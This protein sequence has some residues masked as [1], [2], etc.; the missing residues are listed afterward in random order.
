MRSFANSD[1]WR[2]IGEG[3]N[4]IEA[5]KETWFE[6]EANRIAGE[7]STVTLTAVQ[8]MPRQRTNQRLLHA[9]E[10]HTRWTRT[11]DG[12]EISD[13]FFTCPVISPALASHM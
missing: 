6:A 5:T 13:L 12:R 7:I 4:T 9:N 3:I 11:N 1:A 8:A 2:S 10:F